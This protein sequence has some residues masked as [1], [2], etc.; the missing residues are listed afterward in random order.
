MKQTKQFLRPLLMAIVM[1]ALSPAKAWAEKT[2]KILV[3]DD[4]TS[5]TL[6]YDE[7]SHR[8]SIILYSM[9]EFN[10][11]SNN[12][13]N[14]TLDP[15]MADYR[16]TDCSEW[17]YDF[18][19]V[20]TINGLEYL[21]TSEV[22]SMYGMFR[23]CRKLT[24]LDLSN[25][26]TSK[27]TNMS[28]MFYECQALSS[29]TFPA[30]FNTSKVT[31]MADMF[32][33]CQTLTSL[34]VS[35]FDTQEVTNM[36]GMFSGCQNLTSLSVS[37]FN[38]CNVED[39]SYLFQNCKNLSSLSLANFNTEKVT[40]M[41]LMFYYCSGLTS[42]D[43]SSFVPKN[44]TTMKQMFEGCT[45]L[46]S[47]DLSNFN[48]A[49]VTYMSRMF[50]DC[51]ALTSLDLSSFNTAKVTKLGMM[52]YNCYKL[53]YFK[54]GNFDMSSVLDSDNFNVVANCNAEDKEIIFT[55]IP[56]IKDGTT[57]IKPL[58]NV[59]SIT[60]Q[61]D[62]NSTIFTG[63]TYP[64]AA[65]TTNA[66][67]SHEM[68]NEYETLV[69]PFAVTYTADNGNY[70]LYRL[71]G[72]TGSDLYFTEY[73]DGAEIAAGTPMAVKAVGSK[74]GA[75]KYEISFAGSGAVNTTITPVTKGS[76]TFT[77]TYSDVKLNAGA[78][79]NFDGE[80]FVCTTEQVTESPFRCY[81]TAS[82]EE[83]PAELR[84]VEHT[85]TEV[86][87]AEVPATCTTPGHTAGK[88]CSVCGE[89]LEGLEEIPALGHTFTSKTLTAEPDEH[90]LY[91]YA[92]DRGC[93]A[94]SDDHIVKGNGEGNNIELIAT[95]DSET[96]IT[97]YS[98][99]SVIIEDGKPFYSPVEFTTT[100][101]DMG[102]QFTQSI[103]D[104]VVPATIML[105][106]RMEAGEV[107]T[108]NPQG[109]RTGT[110]FYSFT[111]LDYNSANDRWEANMDIVIDD[112]EAY[113][114]YMVVL[115]DGEEIPFGNAPV[116]FTQTPAE[117]N[118]ISSSD[119]EW[120]F[121]ATN[122][123][124][125]WTAADFGHGEAYYGFAA[126]NETT[127][128]GKFVKVG[129]GASIDPL[130]AYIMKNVQTRG[131][132]SNA[133]SR[134]LTASQLPSTIGV[135]LNETYATGIGTLNTETGEFTFDGW[136]DL[137]GRRISE[138]VK[139]GISVKNDKKILV[140]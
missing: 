137:Q 92:C 17:F 121:V 138:P 43:L 124:K 72:T 31:N 112:L 22:T 42:L 6:L 76:I 110:K 100:D 36:H 98:A 21:N 119:G 16:P 62:D 81:I 122:E 89:V 126:G 111:S 83:L 86:T 102:R 140:K 52:F 8:G 99:E 78:G 23:D 114:P 34:D 3:S 30:S 120:S 5:A 132:A 50:R 108:V 45:K 88:H 39:M 49:K 85:H 133:P 116:T 64:P 46:A 32:F 131:S 56:Y 28:Y 134:A 87:D 136:Y 12:I 37:S 55:S 73:A 123:A 47:I 129:T 69:L 68:S 66:T 33:N 38:T 113:T 104:A 40:T 109:V 13:N 115:T 70:K 106:F 1:M 67:Y 118:N 15:S 95:T 4:A 61:L 58:T 91:A 77:G 96:G 125:V 59:A 54:F 25:F 84:L 24:S 128:E 41:E 105:P 107:S 60:Y 53:K 18:S 9:S 29:I 71:S 130:R 35:C 63:D 26:D 48:T 80:K 82:A 94:H 79:Y 135:R 127:P 74:N 90:G 7:D 20:T 51:Q 117:M 101:V 139:N 75:G 11:W 44:V 97:T 103:G 10:N 14:I 2:F 93:G 57:S 19:G 65:S 27:V